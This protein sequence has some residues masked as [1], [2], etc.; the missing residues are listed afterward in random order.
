ML[1]RPCLIATFLLAATMLLG[2][3]AH[4]EYDILQPAELAGHT[5]SDSDTVIARDPLIYR[6]RSYE[7]Y[8]IIR[9]YN[10]TADPI[11]ILGDRSYI[12]DPQ[13]QSHP[14]P[15]Q[16]IGP[17]AFIKLILPPLPPETITSGP[18]VTIPVGAAADFGPA[19]SE[20]VYQP[21]GTRY[22]NDGHYWEWNSPGPVRMSLTFDRETQPPFTQRFEFG[23]RKL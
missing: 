15:S 2:G 6:M 19:V 22:A 3:C 7:N 4:Y 17:H 23:R 18:T 9:L 12:V 20:I 21:A 5:G 10:P 14:V 11:R 1:P 16:T 13:G 8:L